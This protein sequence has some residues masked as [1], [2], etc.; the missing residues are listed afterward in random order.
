MTLTSKEID[1]VI[2]EVAGEDVLELVK[3]LKGKRNISE[4]KLAQDAKQEINIIRNQLYR[5]YDSNLVSFTRK[6][7]KQK[8]W[9]IYYWTFNDGRVK[10]LRTLL[11]KKRLV[12]LKERLDKE[13]KNQ[14]FLCKNACSR[15]TF[16]QA[17]DTYY[18][19]PE[20]ASLLNQQDNLKTIN[21]IQSEIEILEKE[22]RI[23]QKN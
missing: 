8:G 21:H 1:T 6:K 13:Q 18:K 19:C 16:E 7:D 14:F 3:V 4:F 2:S 17:T 15:L 5:L 22:V 20:C 9:Y 12:K 11:K 23:N 10:D